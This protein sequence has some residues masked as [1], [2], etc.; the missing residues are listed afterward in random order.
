MFIRRISGGRVLIAAIAVVCLASACL[1]SQRVAE[2]GA[3]EEKK[4]EASQGYL[5]DTALV[6]YVRRVGG[7]LVAVSDR[8][9]GPWPFRVTDSPVSGTTV[10]LEAEETRVRMIMIGMTQINRKKVVRRSSVSG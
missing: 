2:L 8:R 5:D 10:Q 9:A 3:E 1:T 4:V 7:T 6:A